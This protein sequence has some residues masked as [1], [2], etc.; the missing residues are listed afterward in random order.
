[1]RIH[2]CE[3]TVKALFPDTAYHY[4]SLLTDGKR[5]DKL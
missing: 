1:M 5:L 3:P 2:F 4:L